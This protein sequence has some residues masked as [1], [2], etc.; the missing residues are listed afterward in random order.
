MAT[1]E[2]EWRHSLALPFR[3]TAVS[4]DHV[5][6]VLQEGGLVVVLIDVQNWI[7]VNAALA[8]ASQA[9]NG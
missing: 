1:A 7:W 5:P 3:N 4:A 6:Q 9:R 8:S 2:S